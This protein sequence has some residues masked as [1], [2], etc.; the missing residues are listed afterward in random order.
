M[1][2]FKPLAASAIAASCGLSALPPAFAWGDQGHEIIAVIAYAHLLPPVRKTVDAM[3]ASDNDALTAKDFVSRSTWADRYRDSDR[4]SS[5]AR[6]EATY[7]W[8]FA[9]IETEGNIS[10]GAACFNHP[11][12]P[13]QTA[14]SEGPARD[15]VVHKVE[16]FSSELRNPNTPRA[17]RILALK[18]LLH[19]VGD[20][21]QP[22]H[23]ADRH[24][25]GGNDVD[26]LYGN[27]LS[28]GNLHSYWDT[29][30]VHKVGAN[31][32]ASGAALNKAIRPADVK[33]WSAGT[34]A[35]W[36]RESHRQARRVAYKFDRASSLTDAPA[37]KVMHL[38]AV[39][40]A[41]ALRVAKLQLSKAGV[42][43]ASMLNDA[44][45]PQP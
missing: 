6:Y 37:G 2:R 3:L 36:A 38:D 20:L 29:E 4:N 17:E 14:A 43:L 11:R 21:H 25:R 9:N 8:H 34:P 10:L 42:R 33:T 39:Y 12:L 24:D 27:L 5:K 32:Q 16:Q 15:C 19:F 44:L 28:P 40:E 1:N 23:V 7:R 18:F 22:L 30:V 31:A 41:R 26:V 13:P 35:Q 45:G